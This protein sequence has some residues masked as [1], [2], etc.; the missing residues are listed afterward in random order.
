MIS[1]LLHRCRAK[2]VQVAVPRRSARLA[3]KAIQ[4]TPVLAA[5]QNLLMHKLGLSTSQ[6]LQTA[7]FDKYLKLFEEGLSLE[8]VQMIHELFSDA[9]SVQDEALL[10]E[11]EALASGIPGWLVV[12]SCPWLRTTCWCGM[13]MA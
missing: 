12:C 5:V 6:R 7:D 10:P 4:C 11:V 9:V 2:A 8:Q 13:C 1:S 3:K